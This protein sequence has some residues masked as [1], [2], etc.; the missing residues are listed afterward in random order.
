MKTG[1]DDPT[2]SH[3]HVQN[4]ASRLGEHP[5]VEYRVPDSSREG[6][7]LAVQDQDVGTGR[8][9]EEG[10]TVTFESEPTP[11]VPPARY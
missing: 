7:V 11:K 3:H 4:R 9:S 1:S 8:S 10:L 2:A 6:G 5:G